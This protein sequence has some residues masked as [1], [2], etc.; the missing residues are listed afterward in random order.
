MNLG[1]ASHMTRSWHQ[2]IKRAPASERTDQ[3]GTVFDSKAELRR[4]EELRLMEKAGLISGLARQREF[5][6][7]FEGRPVVIRSA[8][9]PNGRVCKYTADFVYFQDGKRIWE[10][11][12]GVWTP[13]SRLRIA[14]AEAIYGVEIKIT[15]PA[16]MKGRRKNA[17]G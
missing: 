1:A 11:H 3:F 6:L 13:E 10:E 14:V 2:Q 12:K 7:A 16:V 15:G 9:Y 17:A 5:V 4:W 8:R